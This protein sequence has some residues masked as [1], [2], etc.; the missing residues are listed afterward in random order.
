[1]VEVAKT[2][3]LDEVNS[4]LS[5]S[6]LNHQ[7]AKKALEE[8]ITCGHGEVVRAL[9]DAMASPNNDVSLT[10]EECQEL[11]NKAVQPPKGGH[12]IDVLLATLCHEEECYTR[13][14]EL[15]DKKFNTWNY[16]S[17]SQICTSFQV[18]SEKMTEKM[19]AGFQVLSEKMAATAKSSDRIEMFD[20]SSDR[21]N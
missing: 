16:V 6:K 11:F 12:V 15:M 8:A 20:S 10:E 14:K 7:V 5:K 9:V 21:R 1:M 3:N 13:C 4:V 19:T 2:G 17:M 18:L